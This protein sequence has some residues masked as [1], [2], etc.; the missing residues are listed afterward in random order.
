MVG[1]ETLCGGL[2]DKISRS[3]Q[4]CK[5]FLES[6]IDWTSGEYEA[7]REEVRTAMRVYKR[8]SRKWGKDYWAVI[9]QQ[10]QQDQ[11]DNDIGAMFKL[12]QKLGQRVNKKAGRSKRFHGRTI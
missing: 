7:A 1:K 4:L 5:N 12:L 11:R 9:L 10:T 8:A 3:V 6:W 2:C